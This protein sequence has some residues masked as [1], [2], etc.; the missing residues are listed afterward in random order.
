[1]GFF[2]VAVL[3]N[4]PLGWGGCHLSVYLFLKCITILFTFHT[5]VMFSLIYHNKHSVRGMSWEKL[6]NPHGKL[7]L[8]RMSMCSWMSKIVIW[9]PVIQCLVVL[10]VLKSLS[11]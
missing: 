6:E 1:M 10:F 7:T 11:K 2:W 5:H 3:G 9:V 8:I 4:M